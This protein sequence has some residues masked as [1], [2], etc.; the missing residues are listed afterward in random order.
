MKQPLQKIK[1]INRKKSL[2]KHCRTLVTKITKKYYEVDDKHPPNSAIQGM[3]VIIPC[4]L[5]E[6]TVTYWEW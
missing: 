6:K 5:I 2:D 3:K 1:I 4:H